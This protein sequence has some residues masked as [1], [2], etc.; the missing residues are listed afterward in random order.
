MK[1]LIAHLSHL[2][3]DDRWNRFQ[4]VL[5]ERTQYLT[6]VLEN[7]YQPLNAS[8]V[9]RSA[10]CFG[11]Q[12]VHVIENYNEFNPDREVAMGSSRWLNIQRY[13]EEDNNTLQCIQ[14]LKKKGYRIVATTPHKND[15]NLQDFDITKGKTALLFGTEMEGLT[16]VALQEADEYLKI[17]M[18][19]FTESFN[20]SVA[21]A[22]CLQH[23]SYQLRQE[24]IDWQLNDIAK[25][26]T[27]LNWLRYSIDK[28]DII[29]KGFW[30]NRKEKVR[31]KD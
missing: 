1:E 17:P 6:V 13:N 16:D 5:A 28:S 27:L 25:E 19:G 14:K 18:F 30:H 9:L 15:C 11:I 31:G 3:T 2:V 26:E 8:A 22:V 29:E 12:N 10:D 21:A 4:E 23:L 24:N 7:I 20:L